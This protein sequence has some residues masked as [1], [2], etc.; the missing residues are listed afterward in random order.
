M[1]RKKCHLIHSSNNDFKII[2]TINALSCVTQSMNL[3]KMNKSTYFCTYKTKRLRYNKQTQIS[4]L[5]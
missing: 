1:T 3:E 4:V 5:L 2:I